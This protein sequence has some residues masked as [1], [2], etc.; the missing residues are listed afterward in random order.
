[1]PDPTRLL[2]TL[3]RAVAQF[4]DTPGRRGRVVTLQ[5]AL[6][7][8]VVGDLHGH[9]ENFRAA[10]L[11]AELARNPGRHLVFQE[12][13][14]GPFR[15]PDGSDKS[16]Q[17]LDLI[18]A[19]KCEYPRQIHFLLGNH[20]LSQWTNRRI[21]K[22]D[23]D[24]NDSFYRGICCAYGAHVNQVNEA[25]ADLFALVPV[26]IRTKNR[27]FVSH[28]LPSPLNLKTSL[29]ACL[30]KNGPAEADLLPGGCIHST[31]WGR[32]VTSDNVVSFLKCVDADLL[33]T[34]HIPSQGGFAVPNDRQIILD[35]MGTPAGYCLFPAEE[36][37]T[38]ADLVECIQTF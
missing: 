16:H 17:L 20:E 37:L 10:L 6:D 5:D 28:S 21:A 27:V 32:N 2:G 31:V 25:Y 34:G 15:Y 14:H 11:R 30:E 19:L 12:V 29:L 13:V 8:L 35:A 4:R 9:I 18:A 7:V 23:E 24:L 1:M 26:A 38:H 3:H 22:D 36:S 33:V